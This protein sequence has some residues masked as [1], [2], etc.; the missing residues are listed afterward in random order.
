MGRRLVVLVE[1]LIIPEMSRKGGVKKRHG[2]K[3]KSKPAAEELQA[4]CENVAPTTRS[5]RVVKNKHCCDD[6]GGK[7]GKKGRP[8]KR[9]RAKVSPLFICCHSFLFSK[10]K[11]I[12]AK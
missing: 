11:I 10:R 12:D 3:N 2:K 1:K 9:K 4:A 6:G 7:K 5:G 8:E